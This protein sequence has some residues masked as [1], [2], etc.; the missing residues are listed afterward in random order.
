MFLIAAR[1]IRVG[2][3]FVSKNRRKTAEWSRCTYGSFVP[4][5]LA[6]LLKIFPGSVVQGDMLRLRMMLLRSGKCGLKSRGA[7]TSM[8]AKYGIFAQALCEMVMTVLRDYNTEGPNITAKQVVS[9]LVDS[10]FRE[11]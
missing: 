1:A 10:W 11:C 7:K 4:A 5:V 2:R 3:S 8:F 9:Q 6:T